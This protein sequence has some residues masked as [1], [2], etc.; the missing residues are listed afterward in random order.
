MIRLIFITL[1]FVLTFGC[2]A[3]SKTS[4][5]EGVKKEYKVHTIAFYNVE[6]LFDLENDPNTVFHRSTLRSH[7]YYTQN[8]YNAKLKNLSKVIASIGRVF[9]G[10]TPTIIGLAEVENFNVMND[11]V[12]QEALRD[13]EYSIIHYDS[14]DLRGIDVGL[15][16]KKSVFIPTNSKSHRLK[17]FDADNTSRRIPTRDQLVV[18]GLLEEE[19]VYLIVHHWPSQSGGQRKSASRRI[20]A[21]ELNRKIID[22]IFNLDP[23]AKIINMGDFNDD[24]ISSSIKESLITSSSRN[25]MKTTDMY[26]PMESMYHKGLGTLAWKD[27]WSLFDQIMVSKELTKKDFSSLR[28]YQAGIFN[29]AYLTTSHGKFKG[30]PYRSY[31]NEGWTGGYSDHFPVFIYLIKE[32]GPQNKKQLP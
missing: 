3:P 2:G 22:S 28:F 31:S 21:G 1:V 29:Q 5:T 16:Y 32:R 6:N 7:S 8:V 13:S 12:N 11:L 17:L 30:Y 15:I 18:S 20:K 4:F 9:T 26:N 23:H 25:E 14:P 10:T 24:P 27:S 19:L